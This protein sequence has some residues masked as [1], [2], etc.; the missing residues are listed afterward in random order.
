M[1]MSSWA[2]VMDITWNTA[3][4]P[5]RNKFTGT[6]GANS[7][8]LIQNPANFDGQAVGST[9]DMIAALV[10]VKGS[11]LQVPAFRLAQT[12]KTKRTNTPAVAQVD[13]LV[14][15]SAIPAGFSIENWTDIA[16]NTKIY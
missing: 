2:I 16:Q 13:E 4:S 12:V 7:D 15:S 8:M 3:F 9:G 14:A 11:Y 10:R 6:P 1:N 5:V